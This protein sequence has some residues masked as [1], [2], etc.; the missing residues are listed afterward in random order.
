MDFNLKSYNFNDFS[1]LYIVFFSIV[2]QPIVPI[3]FIFWFILIWVNPVSKPLRSLPKID[4]IELWFIFYYL[5]LAIGMLW[6]DN[7]I[8]GLSKLENKISFILFPI[9]FRFS[10]INLSLKSIFSILIGGLFI[11]LL[12]YECIGLYKTINYSEIQYS[13]YFLGPKFTAFMHRGYYSL[14]LIIGICICIHRI[15]NKDKLQLHLLLY[16]FFAIGLFQ[17]LSKA[18][19]L[20]FV[21][22][23]LIYILFI[24]QNK[25]KKINKKQIAL[26]ILGSIIAIIFS[27]NTVIVRIDKTLYALQNIKLEENNSVETNQARLIMWNT[28]LKV[29]SEN[30]FLGTG[31]GDYNDE[32]IKKNHLFKNYGV[33]KSE[34]NSHNQFLNTFVQ[35]GLIGF[36]VLS[37]IFYSFFRAVI[38]KQ[39]IVLFLIGICFFINFLFESFIETQSGII[40]FCI[41]MTISA[42]SKLSL[43][44]QK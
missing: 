7:H 9:L 24:I 20:C 38:K 6:T 36:L 17:T 2:Y 18:G 44:S 8:F 37:L 3:G 42:S 35:I 14:Y 19:I 25:W 34:L 43:Q 5:V 30:F 21:V 29:I 28:S 15:L 39:K 12:I 31:T 23:H 11:S 13:S 40:L 22:I 26:L 41:L 33:A 10:K 16:F 4:R 27:V 1:L 32:L